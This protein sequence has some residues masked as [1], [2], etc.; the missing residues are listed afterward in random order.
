MK[1]PRILTCPSIVAIVVLATTV[2]PEHVMA[3]V[4]LSEAEL[5]HITA[6]NSAG[7]VPVQAEHLTQRGT[8]INVEGDVQWEQIQ[9]FQQNRLNLSDNAQQNLQSFININAV[10]SNVNVLLNLNF[11]INS[12]TGDIQ[13]F[14]LN[15]IVPTD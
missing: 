1:L 12:S 8:R 3:Q 2:H 7:S 6:G 13:Q 14:N 4:R 11:N 15:G 5:D 9:Q 10:D